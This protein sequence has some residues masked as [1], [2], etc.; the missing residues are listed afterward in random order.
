[1]AKWPFLGLEPGTR[2]LVRQ[3]QVPVLRVSETEPRKESTGRITKVTPYRQSGEVDKGEMASE[4]GHWQ[5]G[6]S[7]GRQ[8]NG[9]RGH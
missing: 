5:D 4:G 1:M 7:R 9:G 6:R 3:A 2:C 8:Q